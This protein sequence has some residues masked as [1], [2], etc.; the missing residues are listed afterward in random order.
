MKKEY[1]SKLFISIIVLSVSL[2][3]ISITSCSKKN[4]EKKNYTINTVNGVE[5]ISN[6]TTPSDTSFKYI[7]SDPII[8]DGKDSI[9]EETLISFD[10]IKINENGDIIVLDTRSCYVHKFD[11][12]GKLLKKFGGKGQGPG[13]VEYPSSLTILNN[14][15]YIKASSY[16]AIFDINGNYIKNI[17]ITEAFPANLYKLNDSILV[18][19]FSKVQIHM[20]NNNEANVEIETSIDL[21]DNK[22]KEIKKIRERKGKSKNIGSISSDMKKVNNILSVYKNKILFSEN[23]VN[24]FIILCYNSE[25][26]LFRKIKKSFIKV[27]EKIDTKKIT[28]VSDGGVVKEFKKR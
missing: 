1:L 22:F 27:D 4:T 19:D 24:D 13:E 2:F 11:K 28:M 23:S 17:N 8:I 18:G 7:I 12:Q 3:S 20:G 6:E 14:E 15:I 25:G 9:S 5:I 10:D 26:N 21:I 16:C